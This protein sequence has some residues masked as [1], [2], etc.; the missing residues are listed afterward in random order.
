MERWAPAHPSAEDIGEELTAVGDTPLPMTPTGDT[1][2]RRRPPSHAHAR[3]TDAKRL[4]P[5][6]AAPS[7]EQVSDRKF[8]MKTGI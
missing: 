6:G 1:A 7:P 2:P 4:M 3:C 5:R 8:A